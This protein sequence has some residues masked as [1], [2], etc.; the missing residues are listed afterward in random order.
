MFNVFLVAIENRT[1]M[2]SVV[3]ISKQGNKQVYQPGEARLSCSN[4]HPRPLS[5]FYW[6]IIYTFFTGILGGPRL[7]K[8][9]LSQV[10]W[11]IMAEEKSLGNSALQARCDTC[12]NA[13]AGA[14]HVTLARRTW[15]RKGTNPPR[16]QKV[17][18][19]KYLVNSNNA[20]YRLPSWSWNVWPSQAKYTYSLSKGD[21]TKVLSIPGSK[22]KV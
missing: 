2:T 4:K 21:N 10:L 8:R 11:S 19:W 1:L 13:S 18:R 16:A 7:M 17:E 3:C 14:S 15:T 12:H 22:L 20:Y 5:G 9:P 6:R